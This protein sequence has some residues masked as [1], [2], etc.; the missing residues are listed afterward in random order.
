MLVTIKQFAFPKQKSRFFVYF[1][2]SLILTK[3]CDK[4]KRVRSMNGNRIK[5][6]DLK[7]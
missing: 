7:R 6:E 2:I 3:L 4:M 1:S 5:I